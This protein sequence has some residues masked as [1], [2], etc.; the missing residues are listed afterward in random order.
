VFGPLMGF[1]L[2]AGIMRGL[3]ETAEVTKVVVTVALMLGMLYLSEWVWN[4]VK[5]R[6][7]NQ[8]FGSRSTISVL[9][10]QITV[11][12]VIALGA[13]VAIAIGLRLL[14]Y[15]TRAGVAMRGAVD[16]PGLLRLNGHN[17]ERLAAL[18]WALG[19]FLAVLAGVL[20]TPIGGGALEAQ[21][22]TLLVLDAF[23]AAMFGRLRS[24]TRTFVGALVLG[25]GANYVLAYFPKTWSWTSNFRISLPMILLFVVLVVLPQDRLRGLAVQR[26]RERFV[27]PS[28]RTAVLAG[29]AMVVVVILLRQLMSAS[30]VTTFTLGMTFAVVALSLTLLTGYSG[31]MNLAALSFGAVGTMVVFH[32]GLHGH[33]LAARTTVWGVAAGVAVTAVVGGLVAL[34]ALRLRGLY[35]ALATMAFG[36]F[37]TDM[38]LQDT[39]DHRLPL[40]HTRFSLFPEGSLL[41]PVLKIGPFDF[42]DPTTFLVGVTVIFALVGIGLVALRNSSYGRRLAA[43]KDSPAA[44]A[45]LGQNLVKLK[46]TV[47]MLSAAIAG[48]GG[49]LMATA[50][51]SVT[52][53]NFAIFVSLALLML[54]V[55]GGIGY[56]SGALAGGLLSGVG[57]GIAVSTFNHLAG[58]HLDLH[59]LFAVLAHL[60]AV[61]PALIGVGLARNPSG[62]VSDII[63]GYRPLARARP[64]LIAGAVIE[65][66]L[67]VLAL[68]GGLTNW[69]FAIL[70]ASLV[71]VLPVIGQVAMPGAFV[72]AGELARRRAEV[73]VELVGID[74]PYTEAGRARLDLALGLDGETQRL[75][76]RQ[77][78]P[79]DRAPESTPHVPA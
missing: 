25:L 65:A 40:L 2:H 46:L 10:A 9:G 45:T 33:G 41:V 52:A 69:W 55:V 79:P 54:T 4:P 73:P 34:P 17:P 12:E 14:F 3:R 1:V 68:A 21:A 37:L 71:M 26:T 6:S 66:A 39:I 22:L 57:F 18:S 48:L 11:H 74:E 47:F 59:G 43:M 49:I 72:E 63:A 53:D 78:A 24:V 61:A 13:A 30:D 51:G 36:V 75:R 5:P 76:S 23:A 67:Y 50:V 70:T 15:R 35:L 62:A 29:A 56:V 44:S 16:D 64:V 60:A 27:V 38:V 19:A 58:H 20:V 7:D 31:E 28:V 77:P 32:V 42:R 8:F